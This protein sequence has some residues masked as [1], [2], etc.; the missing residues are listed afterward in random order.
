M[1]DEEIVNVSTASHF[2]RNEFAFRV[3]SHVADLMRHAAWADGWEA[4]QR[5]TSEP[6]LAEHSIT[7]DGKTWLVRCQ[8]D[9]GHQSPR[10]HGEGVS[11]SRTIGDSA[12]GR[13]LHP[14][15]ALDC[16]ETDDA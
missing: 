1:A 8:M 13:P 7:I 6:C 5:A 4:G 12:P 9:S 10:H 11:W 14:L 16:P 2:A 3:G 15:P